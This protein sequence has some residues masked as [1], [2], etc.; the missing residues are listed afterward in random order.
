MNGFSI[1]GGSVQ[2][3]VSQ[4]KVIWLAMSIRPLLAM[5]I[6]LA[7]LFAPVIAGSGEAMAMAPAADHHAQMMERGH[8]GEQ[9]A[10]SEDSKSDEMSCCVAM[11]AAVAVAPVEQ[12]E[13]QAL[14]SAVDQHSL[15]QPVHGFLAK[16]PTPPP[17]LG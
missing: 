1:N 13:P 7:T 16:L 15:V 11:C 3:K 4:F 8:C 14:A 12:I 5:L 9:P 2:L 6:A 17:R 10:Q